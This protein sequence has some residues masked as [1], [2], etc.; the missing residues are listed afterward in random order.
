M[1]WWPFGWP[2]LQSDNLSWLSILLLLI[3]QS[4]FAVLLP[5]YLRN[6]D[7]RSHHR[8]KMVN[9]F[10]AGYQFV[11]FGYYVAILADLK[12]KDTQSWAVRGLAMLMLINIT[13]TI[14]AYVK[15][16]RQDKLL[17]D[18]HGCKKNCKV[19][20]NKRDKWSLYGWTVVRAALSFIIAVALAL[21]PA[22]VR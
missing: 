1:S 15:A 19:K 4:F 3:F 17:K 12:I 16:R 22:L 8:E 9:E 5:A 20:L 14:M 6:L 2:S 18:M 7:S 10:L 21:H 13:F 11:Y